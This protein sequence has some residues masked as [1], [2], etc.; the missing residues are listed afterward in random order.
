MAGI[1]A[2]IVAGGAVAVELYRQTFAIGWSPYPL[3]LFLASVAL[4]FAFTTVLD[5]VRLTATVSLLAAAVGVALR[6]Y[7]G[8][9]LWTTTWADTSVL[10][11]FGV[12]LVG[13]GARRRSALRFASI[14]GHVFVAAAVVRS[15]PY[16]ETLVLGLV[17]VLLTYG[18]E[19]IRIEKGQGSVFGFVEWVPALIALG[20][21]LPLTVLVARQLS[22]FVNEAP[23]FGPLLAGLAWFQLGLAIPSWQSL[24]RNRGAF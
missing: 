6:E 2:A 16:E 8:S 1:P 23:R 13:A 9:G 14:L 3:G 11:V 24:R 17:T 20:S 18:F 12:V 15:L 21:T 22:Y 10:A 5:S 19:A 7:L 4:V